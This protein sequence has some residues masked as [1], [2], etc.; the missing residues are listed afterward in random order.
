MS[1]NKGQTARLRNDRRAL[2]NLECGTFYRFRGSTRLTGKLGIYPHHRLQPNG[3]TS[4]LS[5]V[6]HSNHAGDGGHDHLGNLSLRAQ[7]VD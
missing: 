4:L 7:K 1:G 6:T 5:K 3:W 2:G